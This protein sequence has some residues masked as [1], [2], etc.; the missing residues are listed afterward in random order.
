[1]EQHS[2]DA[3]LT[4]TNVVLKRNAQAI[5]NATGWE[6]LVDINTIRAFLESEKDNNEVSVEKKRAR[7]KA[8]DGEEPTAKKRPQVPNN[9]LKE[10]R[11]RVTTCSKATSPDLEHPS[12]ILLPEKDCK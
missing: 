10:L 6:D 12:F 9:P 7:T 5:I 3:S 11:H 2:I 8:E 1:V 4:E